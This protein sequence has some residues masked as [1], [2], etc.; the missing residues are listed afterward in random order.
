MK[1]LNFSRQML[2]AIAIIGILIAGLLVAT[3]QPDRSIA[4]PVVQPPIT[5]E[6]MRARGA[7]A[8]AGVVEPS[9]E[10][11]EIGS[12]VPGVVS[13]VYVQAGDQVPVGA[14]L[15][16]I[17][18]RDIVTVIDEARAR[19]AR[20]EQTVAATR[21][22]LGVAEDQLA[23]YRGVD[24]ARAVSKQ[25]VI[26]RR[27][28]SDD[29]RAQV[30]VA[31]AQLAEARAQLRSAQVDYDRHTV[32]APTSAEVLQVRVREGE[33]ATAGPPMGGNRDPLITMGVTRPVHVR[34]DIDENEIERVALGRPAI[35]SP[36]GDSGQQVRAAFVRAEPLIVP[37][38]S[39]TN[40]STE[41]VDVRVLQL[42]YAL[43]MQGHQ[44]FVGQQVDAF[45]PAKAASA[46]RTAAAK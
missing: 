14:P 45:V 43:P 23:L 15:F 39:L 37:K 8:G 41:R 33:F 1:R 26:Q 3:T 19:V 25:E 40:S 2:P 9:S 7:V 4:D 44:Y 30:A 29:A 46:E 18:R 27:G 28:V 42:I 38:R 24:D 34:V 36:R 5:P 35:I 10:L 21:T 16:T 17:D 13:Q 22:S 20:L 32:R 6:A 11:V 31:Q 12:H